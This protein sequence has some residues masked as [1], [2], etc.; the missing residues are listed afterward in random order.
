MDVGWRLGGYPIR[1]GRLP[2]AKIDCFKLG[3]WVAGLVLPW[4]SVFLVLRLVLA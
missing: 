4:S 2:E 1:Q 3:V